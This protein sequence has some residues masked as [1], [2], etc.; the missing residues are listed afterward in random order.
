MSFILKW[1]RPDTTTRIGMRPHRIVELE[2]AIDDAY[3]HVLKLVDHELGAN[4]SIE[5]PQTHFIEATF[6]L[7]NSERIRINLEKIDKTHTRIRIE[8]YFPANMKIAEKSLAV[9]TL[10]RALGSGRDG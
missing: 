1:L 9:E 4:T 7:I 3:R 5:D 6:G 8:A 10:A 2:L